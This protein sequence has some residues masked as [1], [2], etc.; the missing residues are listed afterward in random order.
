[1]GVTGTPALVLEDGTILPGYIPAETLAG[2]LL[3]TGQ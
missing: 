1:V 3:G 2:Y